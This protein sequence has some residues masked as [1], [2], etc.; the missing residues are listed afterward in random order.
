[1]AKIAR[2]SL[3]AKP[4]KRLINIGKEQGRHPHLWVTNGIEYSHGAALSH[5][6]LAYRPLI[7]T[8]KSTLAPPTA[9]TCQ[10][11]PGRPIESRGH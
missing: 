2:P 6:C 10:R 8:T 1:M 9:S 4:Q 11:I 5:H 7:R 3:L